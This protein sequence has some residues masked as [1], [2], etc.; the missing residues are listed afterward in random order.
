MEGCAA[1]SREAVDEEDEE[2]AAAADGAEGEPGISRAEL[3]A[4]EPIL[5]GDREE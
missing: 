3:G 1:E 4:L 5:E 2:V